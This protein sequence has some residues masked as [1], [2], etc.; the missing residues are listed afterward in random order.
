MDIPI[1]K[2]V[3]VTAGRAGEHDT[4]FIMVVMDDGSAW[5]LNDT[6]GLWIEAQPVPGTARW[7]TWPQE[8]NSRRKQ[9]RGPSVGSFDVG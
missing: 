2:P 8:K 1:A 5:Y 3:G 7:N 6:D 9:N 4:A